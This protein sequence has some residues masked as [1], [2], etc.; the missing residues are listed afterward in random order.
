M[1]TKHISDIE[2]LNLPKRKI[3]VLVGGSSPLHSDYLTFG[4]ASIEP[5]IE[6]DPHIHKNE[7]EIIYILSG[8]GTVSVDGKLESIKQGS[9]IKLPIGSEHYIH[10][11]SNE[12]MNFVFCFNAKIKIGGYDNK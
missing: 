6:M 3:R 8:K 2:I 11:T 1:N 7:E 4:V 10:N 12:I 9:V 5:G